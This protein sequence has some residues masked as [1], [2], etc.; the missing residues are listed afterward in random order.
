[1]QTWHGRSNG[2]TNEAL[3]SESNSVRSDVQLR[4]RPLCGQW[5]ERSRFRSSGSPWQHVYYGLTNLVAG[6]TLKLT[7]GQTFVETNLF[8]TVSGTAA[9]PIILT[10]SSTGRATIACTNGNGL[11]LTN[12]NW[13]T[14]DN[15]NFLGNPTNQGHYSSPATT[16]AGIHFNSHAGAVAWTNLVI[17]NCEFSLWGIAIH[18]WDESTS[19]RYL[20]CSILTNYIHDRSHIGVAVF[21][22]PQTSGIS[23]N[24]IVSYNTITNMTGQT[25]LAGSG[26]T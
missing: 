18:G 16:Q 11:S 15:L 5:R 13:L 8:M 4:S 25:D 1:M 20:N 21:V 17:Q 26:F 10:T 9:L 24:W 2:G 14:I 19:G 23:T 12:N 7:S 22:N 6:D 3:V